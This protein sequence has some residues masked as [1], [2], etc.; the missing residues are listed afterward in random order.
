MN[1]GRGLV[2][3]VLVGGE[4]D[5]AENKSNPC[6][7]PPGAEELVPAAKLDCAGTPS[8][9]G[10]WDDVLEVPQDVAAPLHIHAQL[11]LGLLGQQFL[12][13]LLQGGGAPAPGQRGA[14]AGAVA[15]AVGDA[16]LVLAAGGRQH[17]G[18]EVLVGD[19][20]KGNLLE[21]AQGELVVA[22]DG[23][24]VDV[25]AA[26]DV[27]LRGEV[28]AHGFPEVGEDLG[29]VLF[30]VKAGGDDFHADKWT[31]SLQRTVS[32][33]EPLSAVV[34]GMLAVARIVIVDSLNAS[35]LQ[36]LGELAIPV[37]VFE[38]LAAAVGLDDGLDF[39]AKVVVSDHCVSRWR[40][41]YENGSATSCGQEREA[42]YR[43]I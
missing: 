36:L 27:A 43:Y 22:R 35:I 17:V 38:A 28:H 16:V 1:E 37:D 24:D 41:R 25:A 21:G 6:Q 40:E 13:D 3:Q 33:D 9:L 15:A 12:G 8:R 26:R 14:Q 32:R 18:D 39:D 4:S 5:E 20:G 23:R 2:D 31:R 19:G 11:S 42:R 29:D 10:V 34:L 30:G 7:G